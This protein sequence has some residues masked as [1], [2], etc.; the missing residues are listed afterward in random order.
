[1]AIG[2][3]SIQTTAE[4][5]ERFDPDHRDANIERWLAKI[6]QL[7]KIH[8]WPDITK[9]YIVNVRLAGA[10]QAWYHRLDNYDLTWDPIHR[11][12][13]RETNCYI[14]VKKVIQM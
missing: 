4:L 12:V 11:S 6:E 8:G 9:S 14:S 10:E 13:A 1:M 5:V 7:A 2:G 3:L